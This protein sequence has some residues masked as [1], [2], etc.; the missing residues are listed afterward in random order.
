MLVRSATVLI[1]LAFAFPAAAQE[2]NAE[3]ARRFVIGKTFAYSCFEGTRGAGRILA[4]GSVAGT[5]QIQGKGPR[6]QAVLPPNTLRVQGERVCASVRGVPFEPCFNIVQTSARSFRGSV[7]GF[8]FAYCDFTR[9]GGGRR[10]ILRSAA[11]SQ[12]AARQPLAL[13]SGFTQ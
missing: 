6:R 1:G 12:S 13:R 10:E 3:Q 2:L 7:S 9:S 4:D 8:N 5:I 11:R